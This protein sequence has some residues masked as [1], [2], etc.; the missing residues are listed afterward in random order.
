MRALAQSVEVRLRADD[1]KLAALRGKGDLQAFIKRYHDAALHSQLTPKG[2][3][4]AEAFRQ[5][6]YARI[7]LLGRGKMSGVAANIDGV[8][9]AKR[10]YRLVCG[11]SLAKPPTAESRHK[12]RIKISPTAA[13]LLEEMRGEVADQA[14]YAALA[15]RLLRLITDDSPQTEKQKSAEN[16]PAESE[17]NKTRRRPDANKKNPANPSGDGLQIGGGIADKKV[18][19]ATK[20]SALIGGGGGQRHPQLQGDYAVFSRSHDKLATP[21]QLADCD[22]LDELHR[23]FKNHL[24]ELDS[25]TSKLAARLGRKL[26]AKNRDHIYFEREEGLL[27]CRRLARLPTGE[28]K[29]FKSERND[30]WHNSVVSMLIDNSGSMRGQ[31]IAASAVCAAILSKTLERCGV[32]VEI[33]GF[34]TNSWKGGK[35][36]KEWLQRGAKNNPGRLNELLHIVYKDAATPHRRAGRN[37]SLMLNEDLLKE[38]IDGEA[39]LWACSRLAAHGEKRQIL[40]VISDGAPVDD[41]TLSAND[42]GFLERHLKRVIDHIQ[43][44]T[45]VELLAIGIGHDVGNYYRRA[46]TIADTSQIGKSLGDTIA[47]QIESLFTYDN[48]SE[49]N[50][51]K[52]GRRAFSA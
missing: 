16:K 14:R 4:D 15:K 38:N 20:S 41:S 47:D 11:L 49:N 34:T 24:A 9:K 40:L 23:S 10:F 27:D 6:E 22:R 35:A 2:G 31:P 26:M 21:T 32:A 44:D 7:S 50:R 29:I 45:P 33:L 39:L 48:Y 51:R 52:A 25:V 12:T 42:G 17:Q 43:T 30:E 18:E 28:R 3:G 37:L 5:L 36:R 13:K 8:C 1:T 19:R 46:V